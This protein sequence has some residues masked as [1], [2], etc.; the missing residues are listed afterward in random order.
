MKKHNITIDYP[1]FA[2]DL[3]RF[4]QLDCH[5]KIVLNWGKD[6]YM[7]DAKKGKEESK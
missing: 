2:L 7:E 4:Q 6:Y 3:Y 1:Q 5:R